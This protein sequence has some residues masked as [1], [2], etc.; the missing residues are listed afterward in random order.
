MHAA[1]TASIKW[2]GTQSSSS[3]P[4]ALPPYHMS[5]PVCRAA[6]W[7]EKDLQFKVGSRMSL[8]ETNIRILGG[9]LSAFDLSG[10]A[11][12]LERAT[13]LGDLML[14]HFPADTPTGEAQPARC[15]IWRPAGFCR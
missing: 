6:A 15:R 2:P 7:V 14:T 3:L 10:Q 12:F 9:L 1:F 5:C 8:F 4:N 11:P 13:Q